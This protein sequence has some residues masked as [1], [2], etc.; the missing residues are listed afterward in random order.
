[1]RGKSS[2]VLIPLA[3]SV[4]LAIAGCIGSSAS[5]FRADSSDEGQRDKK[6]GV[7]FQDNF[8]RDILDG[9]RW[10]ITQDG[11]F[12][13]FAVDFQNIGVEEESNYRLRLI[14]NTRGTSDPLKYLG[15]RSIR[16]IDF[17]KGREI[18]FDLDWNNQQNGCYLTASLYICPSVGEN[19]KKER[20]WLKFEWTGVPPGKNIRTNVWGRINGGL[21]QLYTDWGPRDEN[22]RAKGKVVKP[23]N[24]R[25]RLLLDKTDIRV[26]V[27]R[28]EIYHGPHSLIFTS[29]YLYL[30]MSSGTNYPTRMV[31]FDNVIVTA[32]VA[33]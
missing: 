9:S 14:A 2:P 18:S 21:K 32:L 3:I 16:K 4:A 13:Q 10:V 22:G 27:D 7:L 11:D 6:G 8:D 26:W 5:E 23:G 31:Y 20:N 28:K 19:P 25:V 24:H 15:V 17:A 29:G 12:N 33:K 1:M 30:Q